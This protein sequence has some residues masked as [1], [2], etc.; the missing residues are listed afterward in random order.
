M[1]QEERVTDIAK[2]LAVRQPTAFYA[3]INYWRKGGITSSAWQEMVK[4]SRD[5]PMPSF[6]QLDREAQLDERAYRDDW[7]DIERLVAHIV[8]LEAKW[9]IPIHRATEKEARKASDL[10]VDCRR[11]K[12]P[13]ACTPA[14]KLLAGFCGACYKA[15]VRAGKPDVGNEKSA[16]LRME[17]AAS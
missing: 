17:E 2:A 1:S 7:D 10:G 14:D 13:V 16:W 6:D 11:C 5:S 4:R 12:R 15:W 3:R 9:L 8:G